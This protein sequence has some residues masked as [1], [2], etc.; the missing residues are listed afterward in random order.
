[1]SGEGVEEGKFAPLA[2][3]NDGSQ[4]LMKRDDFGFGNQDR[5][6]IWNVGA[7]DSSKGKSWIP[8]SATTGGNRDVAWGSF[9][10]DDRV[11]TV[12][13][14]GKLIVWDLDDLKAIY[15]MDMMGGSKPAISPDQKWLAFTT[16]KEVGILDLAAGEVVAMVTTPQVQFP[17]LAFSPG[18][19]RLGLAAFDR[20]FVWDFSNG[21]LYREIPYQGIHVGGNLTWPSDDHVLLG[22]R[23]LIDLENQ[24]KLW[25]YQGA[26]FAQQFGGVT[27][28]VMSDG[29]KPGADRK[30]TRLNSSHIPL[31]RMPSSA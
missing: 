23:Y 12:S 4:V 17:A 10:G 31:S 1:M 2:I 20:L 7:D 3:H 26:E 21:E 30:S 8:Y 19:K 28:F 13:G 15:S 29:E 6:E 16:G 24:V 11:A 25:D 5:V 9:L 22:N 27:W 14:G 18:Q